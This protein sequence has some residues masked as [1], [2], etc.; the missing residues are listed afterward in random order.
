MMGTN[1][2]SNQQRKA[3]SDNKTNLLSYKY[4]EDPCQA[5]TITA[6]EKFTFHSVKTANILIVGPTGSGKSTFLNVL[7]NPNYVSEYEIDSQTQEAQMDKNLFE[8]DNEFFMVQVIDTPGF[9]DSSSNQKSD[10]ELEEMILKF[11]KQ[12]VTELHMVLIT[13]R[14][15]IRFEKSQ[16][17]TIM[18]VLRFL[19]KDMRKNT[20]VLCTFAENT[21]D[22]EKEEWIRKAKKSNINTLLKY[23]HNKVFFTGMLQKGTEMQK[24]VF[25]RELRADQTKI[26]TSAIRSKPIT[27]SGEEHETISNQFKVYES[28]AK[29]SLTLKKLLPSIP[30]LASEIETLKTKLS[31]HENDEK[32]IRMIE[33]YA[34]INKSAIIDQVT[35]WSKLQSAVADYIQKGGTVQSN[36]KGVREQFN[37]LKKAIDELKKTLDNI[38]LFSDDEEELD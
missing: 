3:Q 8:I 23:C 28:A 19:G 2:T 1:L 4:K 30:D 5:T 21:T 7:K 24:Q 36:A 10:F 11:I 31:Y 27:L 32:A 14:Y 6:I 34:H 20:S 37:S 38:D 35:E 12:G 25:S 18:N 22:Q 13:A 15:G 33:K 26:I 16:V 9:G 29:D 17:D